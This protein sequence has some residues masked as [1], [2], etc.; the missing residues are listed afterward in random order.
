MRFLVVKK[1]IG[2][3]CDYS[4]G[5]GYRF[6]WIDADSLEDAIEMEVWPDGRDAET[7]RCGS[8]ST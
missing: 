2:E 6:D 4:I 7:L 5:C 3:G 8:A 1:Q